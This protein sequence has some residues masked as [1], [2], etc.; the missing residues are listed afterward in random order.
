M[1]S[2]KH[3]TK[4][5]EE[6]EK[7]GTKYEDIGGTASNDAPAIEFLE[8]VAGCVNARVNCCGTYFNICMV[9]GVWYCC[10]NGNCK[11]CYKI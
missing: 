5:R 10:R 2:R 1:A 6:L 8:T 11:T 9:P 4:L 7:Q 3:E